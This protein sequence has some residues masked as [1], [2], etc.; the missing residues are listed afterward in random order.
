MW[1]SCV[2]LNQQAF[3][4]GE[5]IKLAV[6]QAIAHVQNVR[7][8]VW[9]CSAAAGELLEMAACGDVAVV[10]RAVRQ[11]APRYK[12]ST[13]LIPQNIPE[14]SFSRV[15]SSFWPMPL[16]FFPPSFLPLLSLLVRVNLHHVFFN[17]KKRGENRALVEACE[18]DTTVNLHSVILSPLLLLHSCS[19]SFFFYWH[20][21]HWT[22]WKLHWAEH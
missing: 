10:L 19:L 15:C 13:F 20:V 17:G 1:A 14:I 7:G 2:A 9:D 12:V 8:S 6:S 3:K 5:Y 11:Q 21:T 18:P 22:S 4:D 16:P